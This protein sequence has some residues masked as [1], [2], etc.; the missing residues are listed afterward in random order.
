[1]KIIVSSDGIIL[2]LGKWYYFNSAN[3]NIL[4]QWM[5][6]FVTANSY[7]NFVIKQVCLGLAEAWWRQQVELKKKTKVLVIIINI[8]D[9]EESWRKF[10]SQ[11][12]DFLIDW[13]WKRK[14]CETNE[15]RII[16][17]VNQWNWCLTIK[18]RLECFVIVAKCKRQTKALTY[19][20]TTPK[21]KV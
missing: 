7:Y 1:M 12:L 10:I 20:K 4:L 14:G 21:Y 2:I 3:T 15:R 18:L 13:R 5:Y 8:L 16:D 6:Y 9:V 11:V 19:S 17:T